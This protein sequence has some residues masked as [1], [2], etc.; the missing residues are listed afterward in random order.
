MMNKNQDNKE[1][2]SKEM[3]II[4]GLDLLIG[5]RPHSLILPLRRCPHGGT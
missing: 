4:S 1:E 3:G 5:M 2:Y